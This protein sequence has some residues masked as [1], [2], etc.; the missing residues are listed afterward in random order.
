[1][2]YPI[3]RHVIL[4]LL[5]ILRVATGRQSWYFSRNGWYTTRTVRTR[6]ILCVV[7]CDKY[8]KVEGMWS[9]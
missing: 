8:D 6:S 2:E 3:Y 4:Y 7:L 9:K 5:Y 1:M